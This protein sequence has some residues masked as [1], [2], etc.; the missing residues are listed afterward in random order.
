MTSIADFCTTL[1]SLH[2][3]LPAIVHESLIDTREIAILQ[4]KAQLIAGVDNTETPIQP[5]YAP[6]TIARKKKKG[7]PYDRVTGYDKG[8][9]Y[10][11]TFDQIEETTFT[12]AS[13][14]YTFGKFIARY[15]ENVYGLT[16]RSLEV[17][18]DATEPILIGKVKNYL[19]V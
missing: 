11:E 9:M 18:R 6:V 12:L 19:G 7:Q 8:D 13:A 5:P 15:G 17:V 3:Q 14:S 1:S 2:V 16:L 10:A 4:Q